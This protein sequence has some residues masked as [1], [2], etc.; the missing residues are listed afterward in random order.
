MKQVRGYT[1]PCAVVLGGYVNG[2]GVIRELAETGVSSIVLLEYE[3]LDRLARYSR[4]LDEVLEFRRGCH[5]SLLSALRRVHERFDYLV[6]FPTDD[7]QCT[8]IAEIREQI[9]AYCFI[10]FDPQTWRHGADKINQYEACESLGVP[11]P[12]TMVVSEVADLESLAGSSFPRLLKPATRQDLLTEGL[13]RNLLLP[14][15]EEL[16]STRDRLTD[17]LRRGVVFLASEVVPG[18]GDAI[19]SYMAYRDANGRILNEWVGK[20]LAQFPDDFG[21]FASASNQCPDI[22]AEQGRTLVHGLDLR[23]INQPEFKYDCRDGTYKLMEI[24]LRSM[25]WHRLGNRSGVPLHATQYCDALGLE[26]PRQNQDRRET[27]HFIYMKHELLNLARRKGYWRTF[28]RNCFGGTRRTWAVWDPRD[29]RPFV[30]DGTR[31]ARMVARSLGS[32]LLSGLPFRRR[33]S[34]EGYPYRTSPAKSACGAGQ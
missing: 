12:E 23:G 16:A 17:L 24:N 31:A 4:Y 14:T 20:K 33:R 2:Y 27:V 1:C 29:P 22:V 15:S 10:P 5:E 25:M 26:T 19:Y 21:V 34:S 28:V 8:M 9:E 32:R 11:Y 30:V 18:D 7:V 13:F 3:G 6:L